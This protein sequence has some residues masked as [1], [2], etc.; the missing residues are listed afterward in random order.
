[1]PRDAAQIK[2]LLEEQRLRDDATL[3]QLRA[4]GGR[5]ADGGDSLVIITTTG[6][7]TGRRHAKPLCVRTDGNDL[8]I[9]GTA[10]GQPKHTQWYV[11][12][13]AHPEVTVE[14]L[15]ETYE[16]DASTVPN[17]LDRDRLFEMM[18]AVIPGIYGYQDRCRNQRQ[19]PIVRLQRR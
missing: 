12:L 13:V 15:G 19:I 10:G 6:A 16:A 9:A 8:I 18:S 2:E 14:Y 1:M 7:K 4:N 3:I 17:S 5:T 11:N